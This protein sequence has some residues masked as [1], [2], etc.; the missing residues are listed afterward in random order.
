MNAADNDFIPR[1]AFPIYDVQNNTIQDAGKTDRKT[2]TFKV[3]ISEPLM[4]SPFLFAN[5]SSNNQGFYGIQNLNF[6]MNMADAKRAFRSALNKIDGVSVGFENSRLAF[7]FISPHPSDLLPSRNVVPYYEVPRYISSNNTTI[8]AGASATLFSQS[9]QLSTIPDKLIIVCR[10]RLQDQTYQDA[11][12]FLAIKKISI[13]FNNASGLCSGFTQQDLFKC[14]A[15]NDV[16]QSWLEWSGKANKAGGAGTG[17][18][19]S[20]TGSVLCLAFGTDIELNADYYAQGSLGNFNLQFQLDV[21][22]TGDADVV[23]EIVVMTVNSGVLVCERGTCS[24]YLGLLTKQDVLD[25]SR[26]QPYS[27]SDVKRLVGGGWFETLKSV[28]GKVLPIARQVM[29]KV[30]NP[31]AQVGAKALKAVG[32]GHKGQHSLEHRLM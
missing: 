29:E 7:T 12:S 19:I 16:N 3:D 20:T 5:P 17:S 11:D 31:I 25:A 18:T 30:D 15:R 6:T 23:P 8:T 1:G 26:Q 14:S 24:T 9:L 32:Y 10:K 27:R 28:A 4:L 13:N 21:E 22:N 2:V